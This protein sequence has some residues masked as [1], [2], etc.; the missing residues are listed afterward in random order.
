MK[1][2][3]YMNFPFRLEGEVFEKIPHEPFAV[4]SLVGGIVLLVLGWRIYRFSLLLIGAAVGSGIGY[5]VGAFFQFSPFYVG[6]PLAILLSLL[7]LKIEKVGA[8][9]AGGACAATP[10]LLLF[11]YPI[12]GP[13]VMVAAAGAFVLAGILTLFLW[14]P[15]II[16][17]ICSL[18]AIG[19]VNGALL[20]CEEYRPELFDRLA[21]SPAFAPLAVGVL[22]LCGILWQ[23]RG[24]KDEGKEED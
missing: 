23:S 12:H 9:V 14:K 19:L 21:D 11:P 22:A 4:V 3:P 13:M 20:F 16:V 1:G 5:A 7:I 10:V 6:V 17:S 24:K 8:F 2:V 18:G 15:I